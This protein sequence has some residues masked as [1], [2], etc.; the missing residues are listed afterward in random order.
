M[1]YRTNFDTYLQDKFD[2][3]QAYQAQENY[4]AP[5]W[6]GYRTAFDRQLQKTWCPNCSSLESYAPLTGFRTEFDMQ[7]QKRFCPK[8]K[9]Y[10][11][12]KYAMT[13]DDP[14]NYL[15]YKNRG[16]CNA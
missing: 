6:P 8:C 10:Y 3:T 16:S 2:R 15:S 12:E 9:P 5:P 7:L 4:N 13:T 14:D 1:S 11:V